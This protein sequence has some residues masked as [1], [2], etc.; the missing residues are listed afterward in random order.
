[1]GR[2]LAIDLGSANTLVY[3]QGDGIV[4]EEPTVVAMDAGS[5]EVVAMGEEAWQMLGG[6][7]GNVLA[8]RPL[9]EG[10]M[11]EIDVTQRMLAVVLRRVGVTR[12][13]KPRVL[14]CIPPSSSP[15]E[16]RAIE[17]AIRYA[18][19][20]QVVP[21]EEPLAAAVGANLPVHEPLGNLVV[22][23]GGGRTEMAVVS[24]G[25]VV[26]GRSASV[27]GFDLDAAIQ[28]HIRGT[29]GVAIGEKS[30]EELKIAIGSAFPSPTSRAATVIGRELSTGNTVEVKVDEDEIRQ[31]MGPAI[32]RLVEE[33]RMTLAEAPPELTHDVLETGMFLTG[34]GSL[35][36]GLDMLLAQECE[37]PVHVVERPLE[38]VVVGAGRMLEHLDDYRSSFQL[39]RRGIP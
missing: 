24:M 11:T 30:A 16:R 2:D 35:L 28:D 17:R 37:V 31:A 29:Y 8:V 39:L 21:V 32:K 4:F 26:S 27:G 34:G 18:G 3:R 5:G 33:A 7:S 25:G 22:D 6:G 1:V 14:V 36:R 20:R 10:T 19:G 9:R 12:F 15:V 23:I 13:P 38:T